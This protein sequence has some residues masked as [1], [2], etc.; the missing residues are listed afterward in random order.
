MSR[1]LVARSTLQISSDWFSSNVAVWSEI[2]QPLR[3]KKQISYLEI[4]SWEGL[5]AFFVA[6]SFEQATITCVDTWEGADEHKETRDLKEIEKR[7]DLN[8]GPFT[9]RIT[10]IKSSSL[11]FYARSDLRPSY[12]FIYIDGSHRSADVLIDAIS[13]FQ[14]LKP[15]GIMIFDDYLWRHYSNLFENPATAINLFLKLTK[16][17]C[18]VNFV[19]EQVALVK[20]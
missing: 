7:F 2:L 19:S 9:K 20:R 18:T 1:F 16:S 6:S 5:S 17:R 4:G 15:S 14:L 13:C 11:N 3:Q 10:K 8:L 12:D